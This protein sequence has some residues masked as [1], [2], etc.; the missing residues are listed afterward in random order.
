MNYFNDCL[1]L[2]DAKN[3]FRKL[4]KELHPDT[5]GYNSQSDF[6]KMYSQFKE[7]AK[8]LKFKTG[9]EADQ[10]FDADKF[11]DLL[12]NFDALENIN[13]SFVGSFIWIE[14]IIK[15]E[16][17]YKQNATY[18]QKST[19][20]SIKIDGFSGCKYAYK[21]QSYFFSPAD[22]KQKFGGKKSLEQIKNTY[23]NSTFKSGGGYKKIS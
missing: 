15:N 11:S 13:I 5:S 1:T 4:S 10:N 18:K 16:D 20:M 22:Y 23:G 8:I 6:I 19:I 17:D 12:A 2:D 14:D 3:K 21:K 9:K 7:V